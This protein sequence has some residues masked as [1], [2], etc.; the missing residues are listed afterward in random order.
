[1]R[2]SVCNWQTSLDDVQR[3]IDGV[4]R[5]MKTLYGAHQ[6]AIK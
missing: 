3:T 6:T 5:A 4:K 2:I 1:M